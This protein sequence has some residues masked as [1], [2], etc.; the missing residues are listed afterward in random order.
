MLAGIDISN[1]QRSNYQALINNYAKDFVI[2]RA[3]W[4]YSVDPMCDVMYQY[5][6]SKGKKLGVYFFPLTSDGSPEAHAEWSYKQVMGYINEAIFAL[7]WES[8][9]GAE[10]N[11]NVNDVNWA[12]RW[13]DRFFELSGVR[14]MIYMNSSLNRSV[15]FQ[16]IVDGNY[17]LW[18]ANYG[19]NN[20]K[21]AG[22]PTVKYWTS[23][24]MHQYTSLLDNGRACDGDTFYGD[25]T[26]W[27]KYAKSTKSV[28]S[29]TKP[30]SSAKTYTQAEV[31]V[32]IK[33]EQSKYQAEVDK[34]LAQLRDSENKLRVCETVVK[35]AKRG[36]EGVMTYGD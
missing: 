18:I 2:C 28:P 30:E 33:S 16:S 1:Y 15:N 36:I 27:A 9:T 3:V 6:K 11:N 17:G 5:A 24:A 12:K 7:D 26:A 22:R 29:E 31:D 13:L 32:I 10:G 25:K 35:D 21:D 23:A 20:G 34:V 8:Y 4:R 14:P 19:A